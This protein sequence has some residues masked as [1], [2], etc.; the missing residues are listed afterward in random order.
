LLLPSFQ[1]AGEGSGLDLSAPHEF[2]I[3]PQEPQERLS[4]PSGQLF[5]FPDVEVL[6]GFKIL[7]PLPVGFGLHLG[8]VIL[9][10]AFVCGDR[11]GPPDES[12]FKGHR[13]SFLLMVIMPFKNKNRPENRG[14]KVIEIKIIKRLI[15][16]SNGIINMDRGLLWAMTG[17]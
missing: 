4:C 17:R 10:Q 2:N 6:D 9:E 14:K 3:A 8:D 12:V 7:P 13:F 11:I 15:L 16:V 5:L 1:G